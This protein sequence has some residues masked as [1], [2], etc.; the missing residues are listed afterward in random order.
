MGSITSPEIKINNILLE[1]I[2]NDQNPFETLTTAK[3]FEQF[4]QTIE[5]RKIQMTENLSIIKEF[6]QDMINM[7]LKKEWI[8][9]LPAPSTILN[10]QSVEAKVKKYQTTIVDYFKKQ[11]F[12][13]SSSSLQNEKD[14]ITIFNPVYEEEK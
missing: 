3:D 13:T 12:L 6:Y 5:E 8:V 2:V 7:P 14:S 10:S 4:Y 11:G 9:I 1:G